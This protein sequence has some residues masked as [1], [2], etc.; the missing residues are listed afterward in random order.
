MQ[1]SSQSAAINPM[2]H[3]SQHE[4]QTKYEF[5]TTQEIFAEQMEI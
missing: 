2:P 1:D 5:V 3:E 4:S